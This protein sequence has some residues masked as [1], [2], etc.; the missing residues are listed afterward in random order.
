MLAALA[1]CASLLLLVVARGTPG[2][3]TTS[4][5]AVLWSRT[6]AGA[7][8]LPSGVSSSLVEI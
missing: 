8:P 1:A 5:S 6:G 3:C 7:G 4:H 2:E